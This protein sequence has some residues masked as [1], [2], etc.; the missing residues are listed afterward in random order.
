MKRALIFDLDNTIYP[1]SSIAAVNLKELYELIDKYAGHLSDE[2]LAR[3]KDDLTRRAFGWVADHYNYSD[4]LR[5]KGIAH[6]ENQTYDLPMHAFEDYHRVKTFPI[7]KYL[8]TMGFSKLQWSKVK[9]LRIEGDFKAIYIV[10]MQLSLK[11]KKDI[12]NEIMQTN[13]YTVD[14]ILAVGD[15]PD[16]EIKAARELGIETFLFDPENRYP[17]AEATYRSTSL[18]DLLT[19]LA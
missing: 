10:D 19:I 7:E 12:F 17:N 3:S 4:K 18:L 14:E 5:S 6:L 8:V 13:G 2:E 16:S 9:M 1:V 11:T 15:D